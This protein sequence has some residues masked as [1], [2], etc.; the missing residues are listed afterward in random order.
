MVEIIIYDPAKNYYEVKELMIN[1]TKFWDQE[2]NEDQF[3]EALNRRINDSINKNGILL[4][5]EDNKTV[6]MIWGEVVFQQTTGTFGRISNFIVRPDQRGKGIGQKLIESVI[7]FFV[8]N[9]VS[10]VQANARDMKKEGRLYLNY[11]FKPMYYV[12]ETK[13]DMDYFTKSY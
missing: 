7:N 6:G 1:L 3:K 8:Q 12:L 2:F 9:N 11:G 5:V 4:A 10:R 13:L